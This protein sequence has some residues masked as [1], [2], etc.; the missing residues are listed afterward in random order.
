MH[1]PAQLQTCVIVGKIINYVYINV[2]LRYRESDQFHR[3]EDI[4]T[5]TITCAL[6]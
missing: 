1:T 5:A 4:I 6:V 2:K 3:A